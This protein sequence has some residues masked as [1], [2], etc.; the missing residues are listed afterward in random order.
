M[1][2]S[3]TDEVASA[4]GSTSAGPVTEAA[5]ERSALGRAIDAVGWHRIRV[6]AFVVYLAVMCVIIV[7]TGVP[8]GR[9]AIA[10]MTVA[11]LATS[12]LGYG[13][14]S[15]GRVVLDWLPFT[16]VLMVYDKTRGLATSIGLPVHQSDV[17]GWERALFGGHVPTV[18]LQQHLYDPHHVFWYDALFSVTYCTHFLATPLI[19]ALLWLRDRT[20]WLRYIARVI[21]LSVAGLIT[22][23]LFPEAPPWLAAQ[24]G[25]LPPVARL[26]GRGFVWLHAPQ[27]EHTL[28]HALES[29]GNQVAA[30]P[31]LHVGFACLIAIFVAGRVRRRWWP[32]LWAYPALMGLSLVYLGEHYV[33]DLLAGLAYAVATHFA[34]SWW[35]RRRAS[36]RAAR[37]VPKT[38]P[39]ST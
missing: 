3:A 10:M 18:W 13:W 38:R 15:L 22:Y 14:R 12:R 7:T 4:G 16:I 9:R 29:G 19:A 8:T 24:N 2:D 20:L 23:V 26:S 34:M 6:G 32:L 27:L 39:A 25:A 17:I 31:S 28:D 1:T 21:V 36:R 35:E 5:R 33:V 11:G 30:M 37:A